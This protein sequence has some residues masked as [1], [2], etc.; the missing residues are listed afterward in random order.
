MKQLFLSLLF[1]SLLFNCSKSDDGITENPYLPNYGFD[2][3]GLINT[4]LPEYSNLLLPGNAVVKYG[5]GIN[6][7]VLY[8]IGNGQYTCFEL[9]DP[10]HTISAC[11]ILTVDGIFAS[12][13]CSD[14]NTYEIVTGQPSDGTEGQYTLKPYRM[15]VSGNIIRVYN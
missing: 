7:F 9:T 14:G 5:Y 1:F 12:C 4:S 3:Q 10:N 13:D 15:E 6:G 8:H 11:S 2:T